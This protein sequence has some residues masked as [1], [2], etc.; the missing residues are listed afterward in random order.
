MQD[1][2]NRLWPHDPQ[3]APSDFPGAVHSACQH[4]AMPSEALLVSSAPHL[5][6]HLVAPSAGNAGR[7]TPDHCLSTNLGLPP[8]IILGQDQH[9]GT[10]PS[11][12]GQHA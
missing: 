7:T 9:T 1:N 5:R 2:D 4:S 6:A 3:T 10:R 12:A 8:A 11:F